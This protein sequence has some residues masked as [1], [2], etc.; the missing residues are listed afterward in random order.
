MVLIAGYGA[1]GAIWYRIIKDLS[2][3]FHLYFVDLLGMGSSGRPKFTALD[4]T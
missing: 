3:K 2:I 4:D 1:G